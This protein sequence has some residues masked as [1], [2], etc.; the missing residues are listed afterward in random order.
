VASLAPTIKEDRVNEIVPGVFHW[1]A[2]HPRIKTEVS[3]YYLQEERVLID[4]MKPPEG[5]EAFDRAA[6][7]A[8]ILMTNRH[9]WRQSGAF[10]DAFGC[11]VHC[12]RAGMHEFTRGERVEPFEPGDELPGGVVAHAV[13][14]ICPDESALF[15]PRR[16][17][18]AC[19][20]GLVRM[21][22]E[23]GFVPDRL[24]GDD[25][26]EVKRGLRDAYARLT[27]L[28]VEHLLLAHGAPV[29]GGGREVLERIGS[30]D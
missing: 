18:L 29:V 6:P 27:D 22:G 13:G 2:M 4:P 3:S 11:T 24:M 25:P 14:A 8:H 15:I 30:G 23:P 1:T 26:E 9:H 17:A 21:N 16:H 7:P 12:N 19:A 5:L 28:D 20:D 10:V